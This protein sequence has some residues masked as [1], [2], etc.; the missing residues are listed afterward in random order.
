MTDVF[1]DEVFIGTVDDPKQFRQ[2]IIEKRREGK[3]P[4]TMNI[5]YNEMENVITIELSR[6]RSIRPVIAVENG[7]SKFT[8]EHIDKMSNDEMTFMDL[9]KQGVVEY[10]DAMEEENAYIAM[11]EADITPEHTH[12]EINPVFIH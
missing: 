12:V 4:Y 6:G 1:L 11:S 5:R 2:V 8:Q 9:V 10:L 3:F 7:K